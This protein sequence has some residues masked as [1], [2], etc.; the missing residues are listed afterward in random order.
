MGGKKI[1][2]EKI[3]VT[4]DTEIPALPKKDERLKQ[5]DDEA[6]HKR[7]DD[8]ATQI[9]QLYKKMSDVAREV[10]SKEFKDAGD[11][12]YDDLNKLLKVKQEERS[13]AYEEF[14]SANIEKD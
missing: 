8:I 5:P 4:I 9:D 14:Q 11:S 6:Y 1:H 7:L 12:R 3:N 2:K 10:K 13:K